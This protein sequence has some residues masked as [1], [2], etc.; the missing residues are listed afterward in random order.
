MMHHHAQSPRPHLGLPGETPHLF[1]AWQHAASVLL[2]QHAAS[3][4]ACHHGDTL[5]LVLP[6]TT[7][8]PVRGAQGAAPLQHQD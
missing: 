4:C 7:G 6:A 8:G 3:F 2:A 5:H 1:F